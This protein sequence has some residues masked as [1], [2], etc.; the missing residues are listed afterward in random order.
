MSIPN[1]KKTLVVD[2]D[3]A[4]LTAQLM[5]LGQMASTETALFHQTAAAKHGMSITDS[6]TLSVLMQEGPMTAGQLA[7]RLSLTSGAITSVIDRLEVA[8]FVKR[9]NDP[10]DRRRVI[11]ELQH[12]KLQAVGK[13]YDSMATAFEKLLATYSIRELQFLINF[14]QVTIEQTKSEINKLT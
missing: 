9:A 2:V 13:T 5:F 6:K 8:G 10:A 12:K 11:V 7:L 4:A 14:Y 1:R 3:R